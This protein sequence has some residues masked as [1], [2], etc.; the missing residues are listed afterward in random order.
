[1]IIN[2]D[3]EFGKRHP[4]YYA[5]LGWDRPFIWQTAGWQGW[6]AALRDIDR[7]FAA[8]A[9]RKQREREERKAATPLPQ[10][11]PTPGMRWSGPRC[12]DCPDDP[13]ACGLNDDCPILIPNEKPPPDIPSEEVRALI[14]AII[15]TLKSDQGIR[16]DLRLAIGQ[17]VQP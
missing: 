15:G 7:I 1:M 8:D 10:I 4:D 2:D 11:E 6:P 16:H 13:L 9:A 3:R 17:E 14:F 12:K 5:A